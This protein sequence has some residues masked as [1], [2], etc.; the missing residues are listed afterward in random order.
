MMCFTRPCCD[1][2]GP[3]M[4]VVF[5]EGSCVNYLVSVRIQP[6]GSLTELSPM[7]AAGRHPN[8]RCNGPLEMSLGCHTTTSRICSRRAGRL[9]Q[10]PTLY[11]KFLVFEWTTPDSTTTHRSCSCT[12]PLAP[13]NLIIM[14]LDAHEYV[15]CKDYA[16]ELNRWL[17]GS[18]PHPGRAP[19]TYPQYRERHAD[20]PNP[21]AHPPPPRIAAASRATGQDISMTD[22]AFFTLLEHNAIPI[23]EAALN[24]SPLRTEWD[25]TLEAEG[26][27]ATVADGT[28]AE[29][30]R[31]DVVVAAEDFRLDAV[32]AA[33]DITIMDFTTTLRQHTRRLQEVM[34]WM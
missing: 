18:G 20:A 16:L 8:L 7:L 27:S 9:R 33:E 19:V 12:Q 31:Q 22:R 14:P 5:P 3:T 34:P 28:G 21:D 11:L 29:G 15:R 17:A 4:T 24:A 2:T 25:L 23:T 13:P 6:N 32:A 30:F 26:A 10:P 1:R